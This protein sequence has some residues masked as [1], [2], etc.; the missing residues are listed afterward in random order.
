MGKGKIE[1]KKRLIRKHIPKKVNFKAYQ[2]A[3]LN[4]S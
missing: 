3:E 2:T 4:I 1:N